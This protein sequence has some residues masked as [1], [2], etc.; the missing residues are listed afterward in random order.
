MTIT[1]DK[2]EW[3]PDSLVL[4]PAHLKAIQASLEKGR[5]VTLTLKP[6]SANEPR[7]ESTYLRML[8][9]SAE[10]YLNKLDP[11]PPRQWSG[12][13]DTRVTRLISLL[14]MLEDWEWRDDREMLRPSPEELL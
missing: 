7:P 5:T 13:V 12:G 10:A 8:K 4:E 3:W 2:P 14:E 6:Y 1:I 9:I 11:N